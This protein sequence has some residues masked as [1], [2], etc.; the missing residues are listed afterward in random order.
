M[1]TA[2][3]MSSD[4]AEKKDA[5][6]EE[7]LRDDLERMMAQEKAAKDAHDV[8]STN[9]INTA[10]IPVNTAS[11]SSAQED[12]RSAVNNTNSTNSINTVSLP[13]NTAGTNNDKSDW[14]FSTNATSS[15]FV[16]PDALP[17]DPNMPPLE[18]IGIFYGAYD[19]EE[20]GVYKNKKDERGV[21][22]KNKARLVAQGY[23][24]KEGID[25]D[26][27]FA[28][29]ARIEAIRLFLAYASYMDI[30]V[31]QI[32]MK[33][34]FL[35]GKIEEEVYVCQPSGLEDP[36]FP[37][38]VY[39]VEKALYGLHRA[40]RAWYETLS[41]W[42]IDL[43][44]MS[45]MGE[46]T[47]FLGLLVKQKE[48]GIFISHDKY[49]ADI[50]KKFDF[51]SVK[52]ATSRPDI[53]FVVCACARFQVTPKATHLQACKKQTIIALSTTEAEYVATANCCGQV[54]H[55]TMDGLEL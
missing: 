3:D 24:Q 28:P 26:E 50:L 51:S 29:V 27:V 41:I 22:V 1:S 23:T 54:E 43:E 38:K 33:S 10:S 53:M 16:H 25:Y 39:K 48:D 36:E 13:V 37:D 46:L 11:P 40:P 6:E 20:E 42:I 34:A 45:S 30:V 5:E 18:D 31:Y 21:V 7:A 19:D 17:D 12:I 32:D 9:S 35:Y 14:I 52:T 8:N 44:E 49:V 15:S 55:S 2:D 4:D 47:F